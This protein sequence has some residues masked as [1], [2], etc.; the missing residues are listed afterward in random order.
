[1]QRVVNWTSII[2]CLVAI[3]FS[4]FAIWF[5]GFEKVEFGDAEDYINAANSFLNGTPYPLRSVFHPMFR[6]P[7]YPMFIAAVWTIFPESVIAVKAAQALLHGATALLAYKTVYTVLRREKPA[8]L[9]ALVVAV[10]PLLAGHTVDFYTEPLHTFLC[11][12]AMFLL[13]K[14]LRDDKSLYLRAIGVGV[15]FGLATLCRPAVLGVAICVV[16][17]AALMKTMSKD[18]RRLKY[19]VASAA[20]FFSIFLA[21]APW[22]YHN[23]RAAGEF[24]LVND[25]FG[26]NLWLGNLPETIRLYEGEGFASKEENKAFADYLWGEVQAKKLAEL[27]GGDNFS[28]LTINQKEKIWRREA[29]ENMRQDYAL[30]ARLML[31]KFRAFW[32]PFLNKFTYGDK[33]VNLVA[34]FVLATYVFGA[35]G[36]YIFFAA[37]ESAGKKYVILLAVTFL[38]TTAIHVLIFGFVR[39]RVPNVDPYLSMLAGVAVWRIA[40]KF[41]PRLENSEAV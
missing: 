35:Y 18:A 21:I 15:V 10:N 27:E 36:M 16:I 34:L 40:V 29:A 1:M 17:V 11:A 41:F 20:M 2:P 33:V 24:I 7:L 22:T 3:A 9:G 14:F 39:Y 19:S 38:V 30:T 6:P 5:F 37:G 13:V 26:Y 4:L 32:T 25:G 23:Y 8:F 12:L 31:G 28:S